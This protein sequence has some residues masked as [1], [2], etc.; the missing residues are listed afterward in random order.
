[1]DQITSQALRF[2]LESQISLQNQVLHLSRWVIDGQNVAHKSLVAYFEAI[3]L[4]MDQ[5]TKEA[6][7]KIV[8]GALELLDPSIL[9]ATH[10]NVLAKT[11]M[12]ADQLSAGIAAMIKRIEDTPLDD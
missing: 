12:M 1:M 8:R 6:R 2:L 7:E 3:L 5:P 4:A 10:L 11:E 9:R